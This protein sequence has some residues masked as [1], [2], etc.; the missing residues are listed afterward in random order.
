MNI[1]YNWLKDFLSVD[2]P[3]EKIAEIL[4][5]IGLEVEKIHKFSSLKSDLKG[6]VIG[7][8]LEVKKHPNADKL[9]VTKVDLGDGK[10]VQIVCGAPNVAKNQKV[11]VATI[12]SKLLLPD[13]KELKIKKSKI[14]GEESFGM[15]CAEDE[16]GISDNH[17][18]IMVLD[19]KAP[20]GKPFKDYINPYEDFIFEIG[21]TPN[22]SD[23]MSHYGVARDLFAKMKFEKQPVDLKTRSASNFVTEVKK[24][25]VSIF[26][27]EKEKCPRYAGLVIQNVKNVESPDWLKNK[28]L[29]IGINPKNLLVDV[30]NFV[31]HDIGQ[32]M[33][34]FD[35]SAIKGNKIIVR[36]AYE[37]EKILAL[38]DQEYELTS[39]DLVIANESEAMAIAGVMGGKK[40]AINEKTT[41]IFLE[42]AYF[43]PVTVRKTSKR[44]GL[45]SDSSFRFERGIDPLITK[46]AIKW[47]AIIIK[48]YI[49]EAIVTEIVDETALTLKPVSISMSF[50]YIR[51]LI[52]ENIS[53]NRIQEIL[54]LL[55]FK[56][57]HS[58]EENLTVEAPLFRTDV[59]RPADVVEEIL[60]I[61]G[62]NTV[63]IPEK[64]HFSVSH[65]QI[66]TPEQ[67]EK[68]VAELLIASG[69]SETMS[70]SLQPKNVASLS[71]NYNEKKAVELLNP[72]SKEHEIMR[73]SLMISGLQNIQYNINRQKENLRFFEWGKI[74]LKEDQSKFEEKNI[75]SLIVTGKHTEEN[76]LENKRPEGFFYFKGIIEKI[77]QR[78]GIE[79]EESPVNLPD[80]TNAIVFKSG[81]SDIL[82]TGQIKPRITKKFD[83]KNPVF[84][85]EIAW[86]DFIDLVR[87]NARKKFKPFSK[88]P[89]IRRDLALLVNKNVS[90]IDLYK[91]AKKT[92]K[93]LIE[94]MNLFDVYEGEKIPEGKKSYA[95]SFV[96]R[97]KDK[98]LNDKQADKIM[99]QILRE[100]EKKHGAKLREQ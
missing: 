75:L 29:S 15:I 10:P 50:D 3:V 34:A 87:E 35:F 73:Q 59:T 19:D 91:T 31:M 14:R 89:S 69:F 94:N 72:L 51:K 79:Y 96:L 98:T 88:F 27:E 23:A 49:P 9:F 32:P 24:Q 65:E 11:P 84:Y 53:D 95:I 99:N 74:Y 17:E 20:V 77:F 46:F 16:L 2:L 90:Y 55:D 28:L 37:G 62:Y 30:T 68:N 48:E 1:S 47:A 39:E 66:P 92:G 57:I 4:T 85:A 41:D 61:Y 58:N 5:D 52:G 21:L 12:G 71:E 54:L 45:S 63:K 13:G 36:N 60:R 43:N 42:S 78:F 22:R 67:L 80:L 86:Q 8:V 81:K 83:I 70:V 40:S 97:A 56:I 25:P 82:K 18:G 44:L 93:D 100:L 76:W 6:V 38:D 7:K 33:H 26:I 64:M